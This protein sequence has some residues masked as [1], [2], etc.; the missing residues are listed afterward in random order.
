MRCGYV[1]RSQR[2]R[3]EPV[4]SVTKAEDTNRANLAI[5]DGEF[6]FSIG[7][8]SFDV[9]PSRAVEKPGQDCLESLHDDQ[10]RW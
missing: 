6:K 2:F 3:I 10:T 4:V 9:S 8:S 5:D 1:D 7:R